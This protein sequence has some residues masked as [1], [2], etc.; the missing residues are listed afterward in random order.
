[1]LMIIFGSDFSTIDVPKNNKIKIMPIHIP[2]KNRFTQLLYFILYNS[3]GL[4][5]IVPFF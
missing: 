4:D 2:K 5:F 3:F 1:M